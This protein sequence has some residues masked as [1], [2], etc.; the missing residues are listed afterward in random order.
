MKT[1][2]WPS[3]DHSL[4]SPSGRMSKRAR[5]AALERERV[6]LFGEAGLQRPEP[7]Q[8]SERQKLE[9]RLRDVRDWYARGMHPRLFKREIAELEAKL[10]AL[11]K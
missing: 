4:L 5:A 11:P 1:G 2:M 8:S 10:A 6:K 7:P 9:Y 3:I